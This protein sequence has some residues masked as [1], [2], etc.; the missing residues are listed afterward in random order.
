MHFLTKNKWRAA[1]PAQGVW[2]LGCL[3]NTLGYYP[4]RIH[5]PYYRSI[6]K[7]TAPDLNTKI[8]N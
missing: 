4:L 3:K 7:G 5:K 6:L 1:H 8:A 2:H